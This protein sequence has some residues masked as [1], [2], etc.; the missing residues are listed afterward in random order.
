MRNGHLVSRA[1]DWIMYSVEAAAIAK[2]VA[3]YGPCMKLP[4]VP[5]LHLRLEQPSDLDLVA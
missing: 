4:A 2:V 5:P 1:S 3:E